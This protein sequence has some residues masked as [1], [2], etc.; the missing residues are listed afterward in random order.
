MIIGRE[1][2]LVELAGE[3]G[4]AG[5]VPIAELVAPGDEGLGRGQQPAVRGRDL[6]TASHDDRA[7][8]ARRL[9]RTAEDREF[10]LPV[11]PNLDPVETALHD[12]ER[13]VRR[14]DLEGLL[15]V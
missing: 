11:L 5:R 13:N 7:F 4:V 3:D 10:G 14:M 12:I 1:V 8:L 2:G 6:L 15:S 9:G